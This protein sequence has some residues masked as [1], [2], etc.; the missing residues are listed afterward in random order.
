VIIHTLQRV[1]ITGEDAAASLIVIVR[2]EIVRQQGSVQSSRSAIA[3]G[4]VSNAAPAPMLALAKAALPTRH[5]M[6]RRMSMAASSALN[7]A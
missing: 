2:G 3:T 5:T 6:T 1:A 7:T 4:S